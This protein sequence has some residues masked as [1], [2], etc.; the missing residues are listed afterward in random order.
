MTVH[1][2]FIPQEPG[3]GSR[4]LP[5]LHARLLGH[6]ESFIHSGRQFGGRPI[7]F[8]RQEHAGCVSITLH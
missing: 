2:A 3:Q 5:F 7:K 1:C 8:G 6:S 4:H